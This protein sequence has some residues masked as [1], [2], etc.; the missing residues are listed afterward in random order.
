[1]AKTEFARDATFGFIHSNLKEWIEE[2]S[3]GRW[4]ARLVESISLKD[5]RAEG[6]SRVAQRLM[7][8]D[9]GAPLVVNAADPSDLDVVAMGVLIAESKGST[10]LCRTGPSFVRARAG[11]STQAATQSRRTPPSDGTGLI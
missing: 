10:V 7:A 1:M 8:H 9:D 5:I 3:S 6:P 11:L 2:R 4:P